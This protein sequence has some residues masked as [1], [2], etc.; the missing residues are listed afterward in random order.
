MMHVWK[1]AL[2]SSVCFAICIAF[3]TY[4]NVLYIVGHQD[5]HFDKTIIE[6]RNPN[7]TDGKVELIFHLH[8]IGEQPFFIESVSTFCRCLS[9]KYD[10]RVLS[11][12]ES[13]DIRVYFDSN[14][15]SNREP[16]SHTLLV[17]LSCCKYP[18]RLQIKEIRE[19]KDNG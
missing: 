9:V 1:H 17:R 16:V 2:N 7:K 3:V 10:S 18:I 8:N 19:N 11:P 6:Y 4:Y 15:I 13:S 5:Y 14:L 12:K